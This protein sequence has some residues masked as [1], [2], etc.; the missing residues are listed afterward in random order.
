MSKVQ[1]N[2]A[3]QQYREI[4][5]EELNLPEFEVDEG[6]NAQI[7]IGEVYCRV[8]WLHDGSIMHRKSTDLV[9]RPVADFVTGT[10]VAVEATVATYD[11][12]GSDG[13]RLIGPDIPWALEKSIGSVRMRIETTLRLRP[14]YS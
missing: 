4:G 12:T 7:Y 13:T 11:F 5:K 1:E 8:K 6:N 14:K 2:A 10:T 3:Y 9:P